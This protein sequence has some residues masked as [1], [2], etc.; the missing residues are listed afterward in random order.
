[1]GKAF[2]PGQCHVCG[3]SE[4]RDVGAKGERHHYRQFN[5]HNVYDFIRH[6]WTDHCENSYRVVTQLR[7]KKVE[8]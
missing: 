3:E 1:M 8:E 5:C 7:S 6:G 2:E 4:Y